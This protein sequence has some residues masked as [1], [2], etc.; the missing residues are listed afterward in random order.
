MT[1]LTLE[2]PR[3]ITDVI[4]K[5]TA[6]A[7]SF[8]VVYFAM[9]VMNP[10]AGLTGVAGLVSANIRW[11]NLLRVFALVSPGSAIGIGLANV[12]YTWYS[13]KG[14]FGTYMVVNILCVAVSLGVY[15]VSQKVGR[16]YVKDLVILAV[17][18]L[19]TGIITK[20]NLV[21]IAILFDGETLGLLFEA[22]V[23]VKI[24]ISVAVFM[25]GYP[26]LML[27]RRV[28]DGNKNEQGSITQ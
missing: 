24:G 20:L 18:G 6:L 16:G 1:V 2:K 11:A 4:M 9:C 15:Y 10:L 28:T 13:G 23:W 21:I 17:F 27:V 3:E 8:G 7:I 22:A 12:A 25:A 19:I 26:L 14:I 5:E